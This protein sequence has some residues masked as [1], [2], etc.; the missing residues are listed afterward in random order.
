M[1]VKTDIHIRGSKVYISARVARIIDCHS[2]DVLALHYAGSEVLL[3]T[4]KG[5]G[6]FFGRLY[7]CSGGFRCSNATL[8]TQLAPESRI[9]D[10][11]CGD[12]VMVDST[13]MVPIITRKNYATQE[14]HL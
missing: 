4:V 8:A 13:P 11:R 6:L 1:R 10:F 3:R 7:P 12:L 2:T 5:D 9:A 14:H